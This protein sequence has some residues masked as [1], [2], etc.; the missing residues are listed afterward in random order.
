MNFRR[1]AAVIFSTLLIA[2]GAAFADTAFPARLDVI[3]KEAGVYRNNI[4][5]ADH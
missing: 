3:E 5:T 4:Y 1:I 2:T